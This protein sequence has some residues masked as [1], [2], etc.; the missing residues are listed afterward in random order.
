MTIRINADYDLPSLSALT[1]SDY[2]SFPAGYNGDDS[3]NG[4]DHATVCLID[5]IEA[6]IPEG[7]KV[8]LHRGFESDGSGEWLQVVAA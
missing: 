8:G 5:A 6:A 3:E 2:V 1:D 4:Y 7:L